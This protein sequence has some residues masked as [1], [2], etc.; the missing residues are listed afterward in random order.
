[1]AS[2]AASIVL[3]SLCLPRIYHKFDEAYV[4]QVFNHMFGTDTDGKSCIKQIDL[5][6]RD[7]RRTGE[8]FWLVFIHFSNAGVKRS[9]ETE[10]FVRRINEGREVNIQYCYP[11]TWYWKARKNN[12]SAKKTEQEEVPR[13]RIMPVEDQEKIEQK[14]TIIKEETVEIKMALE[15][16]DDNQNAT[17]RAQGSTR[18]SECVPRK[19]DWG[20]ESDD[21]ATCDM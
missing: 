17:A 9:A 12:T 14:K 4:E 18:A 15:I 6:G 11:K 10:D 7:D 3:P 21:D 20:A 19:I 2:V 5:V 1:M 16:A 8:A 13:P